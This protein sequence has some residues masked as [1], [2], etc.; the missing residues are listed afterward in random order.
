[1]QTSVCTRPPH[2]FNRPMEERTIIADLE[3][4][5]AESEARHRLL[6]ES[7]AQAVWET[8]AAGLVVADSPS[9]RAYTGQSLEEWL[10]YGWLGAIHPDDRAYAEKHW[11]DA[12]A[13]RSLVDAEFRLRAADGGWRWTNVRAAPVLAADG[14]VEKWAGI[15][16][17]IDARK[18]AEAALRESEARY[19]SLFDNMA[20]GLTLCGVVRDD[21]GRVVDQLYLDLNPAVEQQLGIGRDVFVGRRLS[22]IAPRADFDAWMPI[23]RRV[24]ETGEPW[25]GERH[26]ELT[27]RWYEMSVYRSGEDRLSVFS[28]DVTERKRA[29]IL[30]RESEERQAFL[31]RFSDALRAEPDADAVANRAI[32]MLLDHLRLDR[33]YVTY[34]RPDD[35][36]A[37]IPY[38]IGNDTV[39]PLP[40]TVRLS[41]FQDAY[42]QV[43]DRTFVVEDDFERRGLTEA[44]R[45]ASKALGMRAMVASTMRRG[46]K[47]PLCSMAAVS[48]RPR[49]W[50]SA[51]IAL[52]EEA[53][54]RTWA[55]VERAR[56]EAVLRV[57]EEALA[58]DLA[59]AERLRGLS[60]RLVTQE[61]FEAVY[62]EVL[63]A[64]LAI[65]RADA[66]T[67]QI[68][69]P[70][71]MTL[72]LIASL[73]FSRPVAEHFHV[74][75][76]GSRTACGV[77]LKTGERAF[78]DFPDE[79]ADYG[80]RLLVG[81]GIQSAI[82]LPLVSRTGAPLGMLNAHWRT[83]RHR[84]SERELRFLDLLAR[85]AADLI[86][87]RRA[88]SALRKSEEQ[89]RQFA[90]ASSDVL[91]I[92]N[93]ETLTWTF[94]SPAFEAIYGET[95]EAAL[96]GEGLG[97]WLDLIVEEDRERAL[98]SIARVRA[99]E[100]VTFEYR[101]TRP[102]DGEVRWLRNT[103]FPMRAPNGAIA[104]IGGVGRDITEEKAI[105]DRMEVMVAELQHR[106]RNLIAVVRSI[107]QQTMAATGPTEPFRDVFNHRLEAL[108]RVQGLLS[109]SDEEPVTIEALVRMELD[110]LGAFREAGDR[111]E[112]AGPPVRLRNSVVQTL[113]LG[114]HELAT[115]AR[116]YGALVDGDG[117]LSVTWRITDADG[118]ARRLLLEWAE[119]RTAT[120]IE[121]QP[122]R[123]GYGRELIEKALPY[124]LGAR[125]AYELR[126]EGVRCLIDL[127]LEKGER[128]RRSR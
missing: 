6:V 114:L 125:T 39:P 46:E 35:D 70:D 113:A 123:R 105:A 5:L 53:A 67:I 26:S 37:V 116:K 88:Q 52:V 120:P 96:S 9:W 82:A 68:Y 8:D 84:P 127:P 79:L 13:A 29:E 95:V 56:A 30:L 45:A 115:N 89:F 121:T 102:S 73:N 118:R 38:Q 20:E 21:E 24:A 48:S 66:G 122:E 108:A 42:E 99:G 55:A 92:R 98:D 109:R 62:D 47:R 103:D 87:Q 74:V 14:T 124:A 91:W 65:A 119:S 18:R 27:G 126:P 63:S 77:A 16:I 34:Y 43:L 90:E 107:A 85:Q 49:R 31:L 25:I 106:T 69:D 58:A 75:D 110:A 19:R 61:R 1:M 17:D 4:R 94:L 33:C 54:E 83:P 111:I 50:T 7:W 40:A 78:V 36:E 41:D 81:E 97:S 100:R 128:R 15:N 64:T 44:E 12:T 28:R 112:L 72:E 32:R 117:R 101:V 3:R 22:Q 104:W 59:N 10:G 51:E 60:E 11:R 23:H 86:E 71:T 57:S 93:A 76:A 2:W 80:C